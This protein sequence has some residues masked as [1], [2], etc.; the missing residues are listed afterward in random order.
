[1]NKQAS[2]VIRQRAQGGFTLIELIVV[3][4]ILGILAATALPKFSNLGSDARVA[5]LSA[6]KGAIAAT[7]STAHGQWLINPTATV[8]YEGATI[9]FDTAIASGY[10]RADDGFMAASGI[11]NADY[12]WYAPG[13]AGS[14]TVPAPGATGMT[15][16]P[17]SIVGTTKAAACYIRYTPPGAL[18][19]AP[20]IVVVGT[21]ADC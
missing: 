7:A 10:P 5:S 11:T 21:A 17:N 8:V 4:V 2:T 6:A 12:T 18:N 3:I 16:V 1:M 15:I 13:T 14:T 20:T 19:G 9:T